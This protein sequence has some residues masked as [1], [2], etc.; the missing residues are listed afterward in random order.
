M[1]DVCMCIERSALISLKRILLLL[2][3][4]SVRYTFSKLRD[5]R[6]PAAW[7]LPG[8]VRL[9]ARER[10]CAVHTGHQPP[11][12]WSH[13]RWHAS[14]PTSLCPSDVDVFVRPPLSTPLS[15][16]LAFH[17]ADTEAELAQSS[18]TSRSSCINT[19]PSPTGSE[20]SC[21]VHSWPQSVSYTHLTLPTIYSV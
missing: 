13:A 4:H 21:S 15:H 6:I 1:T 2:L 11:Q 17:D 12:H 7:T 20:Y 9:E 10:E 8:L 16:K 3:L 19:R 14:I 18:C 5:G